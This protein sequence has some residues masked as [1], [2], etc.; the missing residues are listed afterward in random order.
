[1]GGGGV[2]SVYIINPARPQILK[3]VVEKQRRDRINR[4]LE[5]LRVL[6]L[7]LTG[8]QKLHNPKMEKAEILEIAVTYIRNRSGVKTHGQHRWES[9]EDKF[10]LL[11]FKDCLHRTD[12]FINDNSSTARSRLLDQLHS[13]LHHCQLSPIQHNLYNFGIHDGQ[14]EEDLSPNWNELHPTMDSSSSKEDLSPCSPS[15]LQSSFLFS[16]EMGCPPGWLAST[17][18]H[19]RCPVEHDHPPTYLWR[20]WT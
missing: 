15:Y 12:D 11:G 9:P 1:M 10:Y 16:P 7:R 17:P 19:L 3:P 5:E 18:K 2:F 8:N 4:S 6:L 20:P 13:H 14:A